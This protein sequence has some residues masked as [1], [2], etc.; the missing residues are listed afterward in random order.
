MRWIQQRN[1][2][3]CVAVAFLNLLKWSGQKATY[4][5]DYK[6]W[7]EICGI[8]KTGSGLF[9]DVDGFYRLKKHIHLVEIRRFPTLSFIKKELKNGK[10][11]LLTCGWWDGLSR[12]LMPVTAFGDKGFFCVNTD[13]G[14]RWVSEEE[15][16]RRYLQKHTKFRNCP[17][18]HVVRVR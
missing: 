1:E 14:H 6:R 3:S 2:F 13:D 11:I 7:M 9:W 5:K 4:A 12:H 16:T 18:C 10:M 17:I 8:D 15:F